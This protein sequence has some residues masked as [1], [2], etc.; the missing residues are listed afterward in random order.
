MEI[1]SSDSAYFA[2]REMAV[3]GT[4]ISGAAAARGAAF[5]PHPIS[6]EGGEPRSG[7]PGDAHSRNSLDARRMGRPALM[8]LTLA[9]VIQRPPRL[10]PRNGLRFA[11]PLVH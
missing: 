2:L 1:A 7:T 11:A 4:D 5:E 10:T 6:L 8:A 9:Q 3:V